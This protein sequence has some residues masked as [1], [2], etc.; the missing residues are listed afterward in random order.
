MIKFTILTMAFISKGSSF[1]QKTASKL[2]HRDG[3]WDD[4]LNNSKVQQ[5]HRT[6]HHNHKITTHASIFTVYI[7]SHFFPATLEGDAL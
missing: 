7:H 2:K 3:I 1:D 6:P 5:H 4:N